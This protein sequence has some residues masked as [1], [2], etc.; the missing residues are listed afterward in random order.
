MNRSKHGDSLKEMLELHIDV[1]NRT[2]L[3]QHEALCHKRRVS[4]QFL[5]TK[6]F[7]GL[8]GQET[9]LAFTQ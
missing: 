5:E 1:H 6:T 3:E 2:I 8:I 9:A 4:K 7:M